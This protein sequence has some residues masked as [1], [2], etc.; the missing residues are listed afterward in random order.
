M[1]VTNNIILNKFHWFSNQ[2]A[3]VTGF[4]WLNNEYITGKEFLKLITE[5][6]DSF[7]GFQKISKKLNGQY[8]IIIT[9]ENK[10]WAACSHTWS[11]PLFYKM[12]PAGTLISDDAKNLTP[13]N[14]AFEIEN[15][16]KLY[17]LNFGVTPLHHTLNRDICQV[18]PGE[19]VQ[20][21]EQKKI[22]GSVLPFEESNELNTKKADYNDLYLQL[23]NVF[24]R[25]YNYLKNKP[26]LLPLTKGYD[27]RL[28][29]CL[30]K[31]FGHQNVTC[32][33]WGRDKNTE[34]VTAEKVAKQLGYRHVFIPYTKELIQNFTSKNDFLRYVNYTG[35]ISSMP[36]LQDYFAIWEL[37]KR[38]LIHDSTVALPG[39]PGDFLRGAHLD[40]K[41]QEDDIP[42][43]ISK[44]IGALGFSYPL[45]K[46]EKKLLSDYLK[47]HFFTRKSNGWK[48]FEE[49]D[50]K[51]RQCKFIGNSTLLFSF[52][53]IEYLMPLFDMDLLHFFN[54]VP[55]EQKSG[56]KLY[57]STLEK[58]YFEKQK[59]NFDLKPKRTQGNS[60]NS[61]KATL[62]NTLPHFLKE[63]YY[64]MNDNIFYREITKELRNSEPDF[65]FKHPVKPHSFNSYIIQW[66]LQ[67]LTTNK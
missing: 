33:T 8:S 29:A 31:E 56:E 44:I 13:A 21:E 19:I 50:Y 42:Y 39:H 37:K 14:S 60:Y 64:P 46:T 54:K 9:K 27:S 40:S 62:I 10:T 66:Y 25:Y 32:A 3:F 28:L 11:Y 7:E 15:L 30:L 59:V 35:H 17:F 4:T 43:I 41:M 23:N 16:T 47:I 49:W 53:E 65:V 36:F 34:Q 38:K 55:F 6:A 5:N 51:E 24:E 67:F 45:N 52:S 61:K 48:S 18:Q 12:E 20:L 63:V 57:N 1:A 2:N 58:L 22:T 26:V